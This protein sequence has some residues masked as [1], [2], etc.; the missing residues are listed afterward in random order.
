MSYVQGWSNSTPAD[1][2]VVTISPSSGSVL[3]G[4][5]VTDTTN[6]SDLDTTPAGWTQLFRA[7]TTTDAM[8]LQVIYKVSDGSETSVSFDSSSSNA[9]IGGVAEFSGRNTTTPLDVTPVTFSSNTADTTT[10]ISITPVTDNSDLVFV[11]G[12]DDGSSDYSF[13]FSTT[14]GT[15]G[16]WTTR[17][18]QNSGFLNQALGSAVQSTAG[19]L[20]AQVVST[21]GGRAGILIALRV[22]VVPP[23]ITDQPDDT[24]IASGSTGV[25]SIAATGA[26]SYQWETQAPLGG[27]WGNVSGGSGGTTNSYTTPTLTRAA[28]A[29]RLYRCKATNA[30]GTTTSNAAAAMVTD[31]PATYSASVGLVVGSNA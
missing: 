2:C 18:D 11:Q 17:I 23:V 9:S 1:P 30:D 16:A 5:A 12:Q 3:I 7:Q 8:T 27:A 13:S 21:S 19:A 6:A 22:A 4:F 10:S 20:T 15:T 29:G 28:D 25:F 14:S 24:L 31:I 26:T